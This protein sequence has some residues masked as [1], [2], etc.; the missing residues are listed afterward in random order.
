MNVS[1]DG[2]GNVVETIRDY[3]S[4]TESVKVLN[5]NVYNA[6]TNNQ[7]NNNDKNNSNNQ[8]SNNTDVVVELP[9]SKKDPRK[10]DK[11]AEKKK[12]DAYK[13]DINAL[14]KKI[15]QE[16]EKELQD[17]I[18]QE[19]KLDNKRPILKKLVKPD[20]KYEKPSDVIVRDIG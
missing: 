13:V 4:N 19:K 8:D 15:K 10:S 20:D 12:D 3:A 17:E 5:E 16:E 7:K 2:N 1:I 6:L 18:N 9:G 14:K 11:N